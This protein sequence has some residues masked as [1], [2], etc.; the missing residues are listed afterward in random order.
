MRAVTQ[1]SG[2]HREKF[3]FHS[4]AFPITT[5]CAMAERRLSI[6]VEFFGHDRPMSPTTTVNFTLVS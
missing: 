5:Y 1:V 4:L 2:N 3:P 6:Q